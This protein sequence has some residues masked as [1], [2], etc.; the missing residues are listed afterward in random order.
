MCCILI[1]NVWFRLDEG[2]K[3]I[4]REDTNIR[5]ILVKFADNLQFSYFKAQQKHRFYE[6]LL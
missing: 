4:L 1:L 3:T 6:K 5:N 2:K